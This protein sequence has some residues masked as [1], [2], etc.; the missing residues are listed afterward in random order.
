MEEKS[1]TNDFREMSV[2][3]RVFLYLN[4]STFRVAKEIPTASDFRKN[5]RS[6]NVCLPI[7]LISEYS[8][9]KFIF[10]DITDQ[11]LLR[12]LTALF[13]YHI[14]IE[15]FFTKDVLIMGYNYNLYYSKTLFYLALVF[16]AAGF[17]G[18]ILIF[19][20][21]IGHVTKIR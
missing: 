14:I 11:N 6:I 15:I 4:V 9:I 20:S 2:L 19:N 21:S 17:V 3:K 8:V 5:Y 10:Q 1:P 13:A 18:F 7:I 12:C 16:M